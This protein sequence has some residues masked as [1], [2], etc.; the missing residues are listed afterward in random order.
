MDSFTHSVFGMFIAALFPK[1]FS[2]LFLFYTIF[3]ASLS[4]LDVL[5]SPLQ[6]KWNSYYLLHRAGS[7]SL[8]VALPVSA[9]CALIWFKMLHITYI[10]A[11][12]I[13]FLCYIVHLLLDLFTASKIPLLYPLTKTEYR[14]TADRAINFYLFLYSMVNFLLFVILLFVFPEYTTLKTGTFVMIFPYLAYFGIRLSYRLYFALNLE[15]GQD[16]IPGLIPFTYSLYKRKEVDHHLLFEHIFY[17]RL[18]PNHIPSYKIKLELH[19]ENYHYYQQAYQCSRKYRFF[20]KWDGI[21]PFI[22]QE[23]ALNQ[24]HVVLILGESF[25]HMRGYSCHVIFNSLTG[26]IISHNDKFEYAQEVPD[27]VLKK[28]LITP[29]KLP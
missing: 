15:K 16:Y 21:I 28:S 23:K 1:Y 24:I 25:M 3:M 2:F 19:S 9:L 10:I 29:K 8:V 14:I 17:S 6:K 20:K 5:L 22:W 26:E 18:V 27:T 7:H 12:G 13:G 4:D 11:W